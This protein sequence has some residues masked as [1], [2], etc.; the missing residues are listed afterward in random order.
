[1]TIKD[2]PGAWRSEAKRLRIRYGD[3]RLAR[4][5]EVHAEE[6]EHALFRAEEEVLNLEQAAE[7]SGY[8]ADYLGS[9]VRQGKIPNAGRRHAPKIRRADLPRKATRTEEES[10][11]VANPS[12]LTASFG[13]IARA[14]VRS[15]NRRR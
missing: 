4:I 11:S 14:A 12:V 15:K 3:D 2:L 5:C 7:E 13:E 6:L 9:L 8:T 1:M 10:K